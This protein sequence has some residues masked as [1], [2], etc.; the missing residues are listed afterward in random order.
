MFGTALLFTFTAL[1]AEALGETSSE[2][3]GI[4]TFRPPPGSPPQIVDARPEL[5]ERPFFAIS[6][7]REARRLG[8]Q[9]SVRLEAS[10]A[11]DGSVSDVKVVRSLHADLD[12][13]SVEAVKKL[14]FR[15]AR[16]QGRAVAAPVPVRV[17]FSFADQ[18][19]EP[20][21]PDPTATIVTVEIGEE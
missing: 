2:R 4:F 6:Y 1:V 17:T 14:R 9:G 3:Q 8:I 16:Y 20:P 7:S 5:A 11:E 13:A 12:R 19:R 10:V 18:E 15:P 21:A